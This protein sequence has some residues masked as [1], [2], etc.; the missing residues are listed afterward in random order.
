[1]ALPSQNS[2]IYTMVIP[3]TD[4]KVRYRS[5]LVKEQKSLLI[6]QQSEDLD[7]MLETL[8]DVVQS[9]VIDTVDMGTLATFDLEYMFTQIRAKSVGE[10]V[11][12]FFFC[13][14]CTDEKAKVKIP[15]DLTKL[16]VKKSTEHNKK[17]ELF[18]DVGVIMKYPSVQTIQRLEFSDYNDVDMTFDLVVNSI[19]CIYDSEE[20]Y[21][22]KDQ[23]KQELTDFVNNLTQEQFMKIQTF[24]DT[25]PTLKHE[26]DYKCPVCGKEHKS[27]LEGLSNFFL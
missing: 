12:L 21:H 2:P 5:F 14:T 10:V 23:S 22:A 16:E 9:C 3:S 15:I 25:M 8:K 18:G 13:N 17:I 11:E 26:V 6:A 7:V 19:D 24:F 4:Q 20:L 27:V 1:M